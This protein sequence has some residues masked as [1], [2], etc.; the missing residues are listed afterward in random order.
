M[1][2]GK[3]IREGDTL[4]VSS[5]MTNCSFVFKNNFS[6]LLFTEKE[7][8]KL[9][10]SNCSFSGELKNNEIQETL[11]QTKKLLRKHFLFF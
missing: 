1:I 10:A 3:N 9:K 7:N 5:D 4:I 8:A 6:Y 11:K 2:K